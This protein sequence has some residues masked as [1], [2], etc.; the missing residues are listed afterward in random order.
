MKIDY[1]AATAVDSTVNE[2]NGE[3]VRNYS[4]YRNGTAEGLLFADLA[5]TSISAGD[6]YSIGTENGTDAPKAMIVAQNETIHLYDGNL[7]VEAMYDQDGNSVEET[8]WS[9]PKYDSYNSTEY[10]KELENLTEV[11]NQIIAQQYETDGGGNVTIGDLFGGNPM[12]GLVVVGAIVA[13]F[14]AGKAS[15]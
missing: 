15:N 5:N 3:V 9:G 6:T 2:T 1:N 4:N 12:I 7:T 13:L 14:I 8:D 11:Q 10:I